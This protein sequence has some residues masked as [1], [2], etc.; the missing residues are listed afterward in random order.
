MKRLPTT[1]LVA[2]S[3][4]VVACAL[5]VGVSVDV[6]ADTD[7]PIIANLVIESESLVSRSPPRCCG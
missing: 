5:V 4:A 6:Q 7:T 1:A 2:V 3:A